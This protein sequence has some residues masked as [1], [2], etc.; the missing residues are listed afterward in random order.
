[1]EPN[2]SLQSLAGWVIMPAVLA[3]I[4]ATVLY[5][6]HTYAKRKRRRAKDRQ[7]AHR[8]LVLAQLVRRLF[9]AAEFA[10]SRP[11]T[12]PAADVLA[13]LEGERRCLGQALQALPLERFPDAAIVKP[14]L[15]LVICLEDMGAGIRGTLARNQP[16]LFRRLHLRADA[17]IASIVAL[18]KLHFE[19]P[20]FP[21]KRRSEVGMPTTTV[22]RYAVFE[23]MEE[24]YLEPGSIDFEVLVNRQSVRCTIGHEELDRLAKDSQLHPRDDFRR[25]PTIFKHRRELIY[26]AAESLIRAGARSPVIVKYAD[27]QAVRSSLAPLAPPPSSISH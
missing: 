24:I 7:F 26:Q 21:I 19:P 10:F 5:G 11:G 12:T 8:A 16:D 23:F 2:L 13:A 17:A 6:L 27:I 3:P 22:D 15:R 25:H 14:I 20:R 4:V 9:L 18:R 1:M